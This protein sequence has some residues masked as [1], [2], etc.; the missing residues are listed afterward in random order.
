M[1][2]ILLIFANSAVKK[3]MAD[4]DELKR[5]LQESA[6][7]R[8]EE[9]QFYITY[10]RSLSYFV[11]NERSV[12]YDHTNRMSLEDYDFVYFRKAGAVMQQMLSCAIYLRQHGIPFYDQ[13]IYAANSRNKLSQMFKLQSAGIPVPTTLFC[14]HKTRMLRLINTKFKN[15]LP[16]PLIA[17]ATGGTRGAEN[18]LVKSSEELDKLVRGSRR[19]FLIQAFV[20]NDGDLRVLVVNR[21]VRGV[22]RRVA[23]K[24]SHLNNT[25]QGGSAQWQG[26]HSI[27]AVMRHDAEQAA[28]IL[29]RDVAGVDVIIDKETGRHYLLEVNRAPQI[30][31]AS[32]PEEKA[33]VVIDAIKE[34]IESHLPL[35]A[36]IESKGRDKRIIG[37]F[38][39]V[40]LPGGV[41]A[42]AKVD[43]GADTSSVHCE[44]VEEVTRSGK[45]VLRFSFSETGDDWHETDTFS[46]IKVKSSNGHVSTRYAVPL[47]LS[48][49]DHKYICPTTLSK[50]HD[51]SHGMLIGRRFLRDNGMVVDVA[52][53]FIIT[54][55]KGMVGV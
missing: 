28:V 25:S 14:R 33:N 22:I 40:I 49:G 9:M 15:D 5:I 54:R 18:Y 51:M 4:A 8:G 10:A 13:E 38:E 32:F 37:R 17:K 26:A 42:V 7:L 3:G 35:G 20:P 41:V 16:F 30:E 27:N 1:K 45:Q 24:G 44:R 55:Q 46:V 52:R 31:H 29:K 12:I 36:S 53:R 19:H 21:K 47:E 50:R 34:T 2:K 6:N 11:S 48:I 43:T 23:V 39:R